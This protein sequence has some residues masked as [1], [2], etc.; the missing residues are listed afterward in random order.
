MRT[1][2]EISH[3]AFYNMGKYSQLVIDLVEEFKD[4]ENEPE[5]YG[6][7]AYTIMNILEVIDK[8]RTDDVRL[9]TELLELANVNSEIVNNTQ[10]PAK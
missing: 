7:L 8:S 4:I 1:I 9:L 2:E 10:F 6:A 5:D 3:D